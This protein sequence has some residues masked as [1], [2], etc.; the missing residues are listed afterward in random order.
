MLVKSTSI[1][2]RNFWFA[3][4]C[5]IVWLTPPQGSAHAGDT[6]PLVLPKAS[7]TIPAQRIGWNFDNVSELL[8]K[9][10]ADEKPIVAVMITK[11]CGWCRIFLAHVLR[12]NQL[13]TFAGQ[14]HFAIL[15]APESKPGIED[16]QADLDNKQFMNLLKVEGYPTTAIVSVKKKSFSA[17]GKISGAASEGGIIRLLTAAGLKAGES[18]PQIGQAAAVG[19]PI[20]AACGGNATTDLLAPSAPTD[21]QRGISP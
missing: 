6:K 19:L 21:V 5:G 17:I 10:N 4:L 14:A 1:G 18:A 15:Y 11:R 16:S 20:P 8:T 12:C 7:E 3:S 2:L 9:A 13:N